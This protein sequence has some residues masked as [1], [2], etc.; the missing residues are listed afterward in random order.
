MS[1][2]IQHLVWTLY[3]KE[4]VSDDKRRGSTYCVKICKKN[5]SKTTY[6]V[7][8]L[9]TL[10]TLQMHKADHKVDRHGKVSRLD[11]SS[12]IIVFVRFLQ[13]IQWYCVYSVKFNYFGGTS[14]FLR[15]LKVH[16]VKRGL[17]VFLKYFLW[18]HRNG[19]IWGI[20]LLNLMSWGVCWQFTVWW[21]RWG[22]RKEVFRDYVLCLLGWCRFS[23]IWSICISLILIGIKV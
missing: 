15:C 9:N 10:E 17:T 14:N 11:C 2:N 1:L 19:C 16:Y 6:T 22:G 21:Q 23:S 8:L 12:Q 20:K 18:L 3:V 4:V 7:K 5:N 13:F